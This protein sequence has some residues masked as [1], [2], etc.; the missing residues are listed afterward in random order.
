MLTSRW[1]VALAKS[2]GFDVAGV[3]TAYPVPTL[4][5][6][7]TWLS[8]GYHGDMAYL[9]RPDRVVRRANPELVLPGVRSVV[10]VGLNYYQEEPS[11]P[12]PRDPGRGSVARYAWGTDYHDLMLRRLEKLAARMAYE[13]PGVECR[14]Y[15]DTGPVLERAYAARAGLGFIGKN[16]ALISPTFGPWLFLGEVLTTAKLEQTPPSTGSCGSCRR[17][18]DA[19]PTGAIVS[20]YVVDAR[21]CLS[22]L[23]IELRGPIPEHLRS[24]LGTRVFG[25][26]V[27]HEMCPW[28]RFATPTSENAF[29]PRPRFDVAPHLGS[30]ALLSREDFARRYDGRP[31]ARAGRDG[32]ARNAIVALANSGDPQAEA[33][34]THVAAEGDEATRALA[35]WA[36]RRLARTTAGWPAGGAEAADLRRSTQH[37]SYPASLAR[38]DYST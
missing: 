11:H 37:A 3:T 9:A 30:L 33:P 10:C 12:S 17:C 21:R 36:L 26:D 13:S 34:L 23:T 14:C 8:C 28:H 5:A 24:Q 15:V 1:V 22:Y 4:N 32:L 31:I 25:C 7:R 2:L 20:P 18:I 38:R 6:Y 16:G 19:C 35:E 29:R 27:C